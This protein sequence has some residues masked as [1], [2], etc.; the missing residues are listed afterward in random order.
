MDNIEKAM[1]VLYRPIVKEHKEK[2]LIDEY[3]GDLF[4]EAMLS[5]PMSAVVSSVVFFWNLG[6]DCTS[7]MMSS[8][9]EGTDREVQRILR[10]DLGTSGVTTSQSTRSVMEMLRS[11]KM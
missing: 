1:A 8:L 5:M 4:H 7:V 11:L 6:R 3:K 2:Y 10:Q 9:E